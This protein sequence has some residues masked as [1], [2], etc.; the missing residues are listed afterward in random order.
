MPKV[1]AVARGLQVG[2]FNTWAETEPLVKG[3]VGAKYK[4][5]PSMDEAKAFLSES[6]SPQ[7]V[8]KGTSKPSTGK[9]YAVARGK[10]VGI[11]NTW[12]ETEPLVKGYVGAKYKS[13]PSMDEAKAFLSESASPPNIQ[14]AA[15]PPTPSPAFQTPA[16]APMQPPLT[17]DAPGILRPQVVYTDGACPSNG[18]RGARGGYGV[19]FEPNPYQELPDGTICPV[20]H[21]MGEDPRHISNPLHPGDNVTNN[22]AEMRG[23]IAALEWAASSKSACYNHEGMGW[24]RLKPG[25]PLHIYTDSTYCIKGVTQYLQNWLANG[26]KKADTSPV[27]NKDLWL[28]IHNGLQEV[29]GKFESHLSQATG[30]GQKRGRGSAE[31]DAVVFFHVKGHSGVRGNEAADGLAVRGASMHNCN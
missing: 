30:V 14:P 23:V 13:F 25:Q 9:V 4:S 26:F 27:L 16:A 21:G 11:F 20:K 18:Q 6:A 31:S 15:P 3:Y 29:R 5:F 12:A 22:V 28:A 8:S 24:G 17:Q 19:F 1:Y 7:V 10:Q 2:I